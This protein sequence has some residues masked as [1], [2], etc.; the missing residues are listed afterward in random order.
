M[1]DVS[2]ARSSTE[3]VAPAKALVL[4]IHGH[5]SDVRAVVVSEDGTT[6]A[7]CSSEGVKF[8]RHLQVLVC[9]AV[10][11]AMVSLLLSLQA[12]SIW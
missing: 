3:R 1:F 10:P 8:G 7:T 6:L 11:V 12:R 9:V 5:R 2:V 4:D